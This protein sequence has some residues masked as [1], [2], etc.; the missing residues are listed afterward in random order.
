MAASTFLLTTSIERLNNSVKEGMV[1]FPAMRGC[2]GCEHQSFHH[3]SK[4]LQRTVPCC[5]N[6]KSL[7]QRL[8]ILVLV[9]YFRRVVLCWKPQ[10]NMLQQHSGLG[11]LAQSRKF[12]IKIEYFILGTLGKGRTAQ[13]A[14]HIGGYSLEAS[15]ENQAW[16]PP[17]RRIQPGIILQ[18]TWLGERVQIE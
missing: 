4:Y 18:W 1:S 11:K 13:W 7:T 12:K 5:K 10:S 15:G 14:G 8:D 2:H 16:N 3:I 6:D 9:N 17:F